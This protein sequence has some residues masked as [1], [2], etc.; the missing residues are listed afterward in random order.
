MFEDVMMLKGELGCLFRST[1]VKICRYNEQLNGS[2][3][4]MT[5]GKEKRS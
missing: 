1:G 2:E 3:I 5:L 4:V